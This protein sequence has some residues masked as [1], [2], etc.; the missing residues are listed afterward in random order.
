VF[1]V[2]SARLC[3]LPATRWNDEFI[4]KV[5]EAAEKDPL[6]QETRALAGKSVDD[7]LISSEDGILYRKGMLWVPCGLVPSV[8]KSEHDSK[9][10]GHFGQDK[11][12]ELVRRHFWWPKMNEAIVDYIRSCPDC[13]RDKSRRHRQYGLL[14]PLELPHAPWQSIAMDFITDLPASD[15]HTELWVVVDRFTKMAHFIPLRKDQKK[16]ED[17]CH[18]FAREIW[19]LHGVPRDIVSDR[20]SRF[21]SS[22]WQVFLAILGVRPRIST[23][24]HPQTDGQTER[25]NQVI[26][27]YIRSYISHEM[28]DWVDLLPMAEYA[29]NNTATSATGMTPFYANYGWH[30]ETVNPGKAEVSNPASEAYAHWARRS[31]ETNRRMLKAARERMIKYGD[32]KR[33]EAHKYQVGDMVLLSARTLRTKRPSRKFDHKFLGPF[34]IEKVVTPAAMLLHL[35]GL[36]RC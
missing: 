34:Q 19:R 28:D 26:E 7:S 31:I 32:R 8:L 13:Q 11:T 35:A 12:I 1:V 5:R 22:T 25:T 4:Q 33:K 10:A 23:S 18:V 27:A 36:P 29:Y 17:L 30:P 21:T 6:Y 16:A 9:I 2:S 3:S 24:F 15:G 20:D 14:S